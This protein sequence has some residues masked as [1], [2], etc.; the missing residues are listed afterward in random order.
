GSLNTSNFNLID[1][2]ACLA[3]LGFYGGT[4][5]TY[6]LLSDSPAINA[7]NPVYN[8]STQGTDDQRGAVRVTGGRI[9]IGAFENNIDFD[10]SSLPNGSAGTSYS[11]QLSATRQPTFSK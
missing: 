6:A 9:D 7:G 5:Q 2:D 4:T 3:P 11:Q 8:S 1:S 10:Q